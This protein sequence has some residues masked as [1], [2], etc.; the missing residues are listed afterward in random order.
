MAPFFEL[1]TTM[2]VQWCARRT[3][4]NFSASYDKIF[5]ADTRKVPVAIDESLHKKRYTKF[6]VA[7]GR[8]TDD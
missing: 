6:L 7:L 3:R 4:A 1:E 2:N 5:V 8:A